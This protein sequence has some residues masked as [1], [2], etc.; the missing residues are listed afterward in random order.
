[1]VVHRSSY[2]TDSMAFSMVFMA[3]C[4]VLFLSHLWCQYSLLKL[5]AIDFT[6]ITSYTV[7]VIADSRQGLQ[8]FK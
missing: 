2:L 1:M 3:I 5:M 7:V 6:Q 8:H 4:G